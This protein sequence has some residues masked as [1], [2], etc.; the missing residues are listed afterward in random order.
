MGRRSAL[1]PAIARS[2]ALAAR[3]IDWRAVLAG[4]GAAAA[5]KIPAE[6]IATAT[7]GSH[8]GSEL[9]ELLVRFVAMLRVGNS[10]RERCRE[11]HSATWAM[12]NAEVQREL[13]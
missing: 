10:V 8:N 4:T 1:C 5:A 11:L 13:V 12:A 7:A 6:P 2:S 3:K 9:R